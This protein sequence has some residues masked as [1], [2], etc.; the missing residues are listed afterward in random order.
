MLG[1]CL[2]PSEGSQFVLHADT[3]NALVGC[4]W[5][6]TEWRIARDVPAGAIGSDRQCRLSPMLS[7]VFFGWSFAQGLQ[8]KVS[9]F[10]PVAKVLT[11]CGDDL[12]LQTVQRFGV[13]GFHRAGGSGDEA[14]DVLR[15]SFRHTAGADC[16]DRDSLPSGGVKDGAI[17]GNPL[18]DGVP[19]FVFLLFGLVGGQLCAAGPEYLG[20]HRSGVGELVWA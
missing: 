10:G 12:R 1:L 17:L 2:W 6:G 11:R 16:L 14:E 4:P 18:R 13:L 5:R 3:V 9:S 19:T 20:Q 15:A 8:P 7:C